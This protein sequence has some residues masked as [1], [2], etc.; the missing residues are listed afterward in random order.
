MIQPA[1][2]PTRSWI[3]NIHRLVLNIDRGQIILI[4]NESCRMFFLL[5][6]LLEIISSTVLINGVFIL[7]SNCQAFL[8]TIVFENSL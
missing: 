6:F 8:Q 5:I 1:F 2:L 4:S 7:Y 3:K